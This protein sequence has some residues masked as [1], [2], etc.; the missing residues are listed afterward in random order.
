MI[1]KLYSSIK[2]KGIILSFR[3]MAIRLASKIIA[4]PFVIF[5]IL[6]KPLIRIRFIQLFSARIGHYSFNTEAILCALDLKLDNDRKTKTLFYTS[7][8][9]SI[10]NNHLHLMWKRVIPLVPF[11]SIA[12]EIDKLLMR[13]GG[14]KYHRDTLKKIFEPGC[15]G[16]DRWG[17]L[18]KVERCHLSFT[19]P[20]LQKGAILLN[21]MGIPTDAKYICLLARDSQY[22]NT[23]MPSVDWTYHDYRDADINSYQMAVQ[24]LVDQ[25]YYV[26]RMGKSVKE[27]FV[28]NHP[29]VIDYAMS[30]FRSD[31]LDI[32]L[33][34]HC[35]FFISTC[36]G[37]D[38]IA[39]I[40]R[41]PLLV[42]NLGLP[43]FDIWHPWNLFIP[44]KIFNKKNNRFLTFKEMKYILKKMMPRKNIPE[45]LKENNLC[46]VNN[47][48][49]EIKDVVKEMVQLLTG[50]LHYSNEDNMLQQQFW[51]EF[52]KYLKESNLPELELPVCEE[53]L[54]R[55][56][57]AF[58][59]NNISLFQNE[60][61][62][63]EMEYD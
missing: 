17:L 22:L 19:Q 59:K 58:L 7:S 5:I 33:S 30:D 1:N 16:R 53:I 15:D 21:K 44:K 45:V 12:N 3:I 28:F 11:S 36:S 25:G 32:Y 61:K 10:C 18:R 29:H 27:A 56:G 37:L 57:S 2:N 52:P 46:F 43:D 54:M 26:I 13:F 40:F 14:N 6:I 9:L 49:I 23:Y 35:F 47:T 20:E 50:S 24:Y 51:H 41:K 60:K 8:E 48:A 62:M 39:R 38:S 63:Q 55:V 31:F 42:T 34:A 4:I